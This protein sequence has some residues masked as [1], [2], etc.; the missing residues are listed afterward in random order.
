MHATSTPSNSGSTGEI[1]ASCRVPLLVLFFSAA[2]WLLI[3]SVFG[4]VASL[5]FHSPKLAANCAWLTSGRVHAVALNALLYGFAIPAGLGAALWIFARLGGSPA[6]QPLVIALG[7]KL[8]NLGVL[9]GAAG[10]L[11]GDS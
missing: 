6:S 1:D 7:G 5:K 8:W 10:I 11:L 3:A 9:A 2:A 4:L